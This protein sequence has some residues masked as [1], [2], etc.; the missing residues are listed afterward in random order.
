MD[1]SLIRLTLIVFLVIIFPLAQKQW[2]NLYLFDINQF[3]FY[4]LLYYLSGLLCPLLV[5][6]NSIDKFTYYSFTNN[7]LRINNSIKGKLLLLNIAV[8]LIALS[9]FI[10]TYIFI[11]FDFIINLFFDNNYQFTIDI[12]KQILFILF[13]SL[14]LIFKKTKFFIKKFI[15]FNFFLSSIFIW[16][17]Q[18]NNNFLSQKFLINEFIDLNNLNFANIILILSIEVLFYIWSYISY[19]TNLSD[20]IVPIPFKNDLKM[21]FKIFLFYFSIIVYYSILEQ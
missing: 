13:F 21:I 4:K 9:I 2:L 16:Y 14:L 1:F 3:S 8:F 19:Q 6:R 18:L 5:C 7:N 11:N 12:D 17:L 20:W 15:L 10:S